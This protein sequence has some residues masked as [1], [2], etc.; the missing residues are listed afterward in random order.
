MQLEK[1][2]FLLEQKAL[3]L[4]D[5]IVATIGTL[6]DQRIYSWNQ[7]SKITT[8]FLDEVGQTKQTEMPFLF[9]FGQKRTCLIGDH[10]QLK[11]LVHSLAASHA[12][13]EKSIMEWLDLGCVLFYLFIVFIIKLHNYLINFFS[14][15]KVP[16]TLLKEQHRMTPTIR[17]F[18]S[19]LTYNDELR[20]A[21]SVLTRLNEIPLSVYPGN[22]YLE[23]NDIIV[24][25]HNGVE[26]KVT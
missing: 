11:P 23:K 21:E 10:L 6:S 3:G 22:A 16:W 2:V 1:H 4:F 25:N 9:T 24:F 7:G 20:D 17:D 14:G 13:L 5:V 26:Q 18:T 12:G 19:Y 15:K 8:L